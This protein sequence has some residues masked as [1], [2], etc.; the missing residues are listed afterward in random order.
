MSRATPRLYCVQMHDPSAIDV[1]LEE[2]RCDS[3]VREALPLCTCQR[4]EIVL[5]ASDELPELKNMTQIAVDGDAAERLF[6]IASG[7]LSD[8]PGERAVA[9][10]LRRQLRAAL[11]T[12]HAGTN[13]AKLARRALSASEELRER[14]EQETPILEVA[15]LIVKHV[16]DDSRITLLGGGMVGHSIHA[17]LERAELTPTIWATRNPQG[18]TGSPLAATRADAQHTP[19]E[20]T[21]SPDKTSR[22]TR[23]THTIHEALTSLNETDILITALGQLESPLDASPLPVHVTTIDLGVPANLSRPTWT[24]QSIIKQHDS[25]LEAQRGRVER[26]AHRLR[27]KAEAALAETLCPTMTEINGSI[28]QFRQAIIDAEMK[29]LAPTFDSLPEREADELRRSIRHT[30]ARCVHP[31][32][33]YVNTLGRQG[34]AEDAALVVDHLLG[35][36]VGWSESSQP[37]TKSVR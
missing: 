1:L 14:V 11:K 4:C 33:E 36:R 28:A 31:L 17:A 25:L 2:L 7:A 30:A 37:R 19:K 24:Y 13:L 10:Q 22:G 3:T 26:A 6:A 29:R 32:H 21:A 15:D 35:S 12:G 20:S 27:A 9:E 16:A 18:A 5:L 23:P 8:I 34:R